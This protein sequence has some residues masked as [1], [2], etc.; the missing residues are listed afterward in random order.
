MLFICG[1]RME[2]GKLIRFIQLESLILCLLEAASTSRKEEQKRK[3]ENYNE[4]NLLCSLADREGA[5]DK[6]E[7]ARSI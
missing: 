4:E 3:K 2:I 7:L 1:V 6:I 5:N